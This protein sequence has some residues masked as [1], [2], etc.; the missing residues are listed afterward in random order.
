VLAVIICYEIFLLGYYIGKAH[1]P[2]AVGRS[3]NAKKLLLVSIDGFRFEYLARG[4]TPHL[5]KLAKHGYTARLIPQFPSYTFPNHYSLVT[6]LF[7]ESHGI[8]SNSFF[9][10]KL[11]KYF[12]FTNSTSFLP[13]FWNAD[14]V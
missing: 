8:V 6:G 1:V 14:P 4:K 11:Q 13:N 9:D 7:P 5:A 2:P 10:P 3:K 12:Y